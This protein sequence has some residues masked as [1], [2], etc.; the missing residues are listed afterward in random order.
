MNTNLYRSTICL[1]PGNPVN[2]NDPPSSIHLHACT[3]IQSIADTTTH[4]YDFGRLLPLIVT[5]SDHYFIVS[6]DGKRAHVMF[7][8]KIFTEWSTHQLSPHT[9]RCCEVPLTAL[10]SGGRHRLAKLH[11]MRESQ[12][13][14]LAGRLAGLVEA[15]VFG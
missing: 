9:R 10:P 8:A 6:P 15:R 4:S 14:E 13:M 11:S 7:L 2:V 5:P 1:L 3:S 12:R